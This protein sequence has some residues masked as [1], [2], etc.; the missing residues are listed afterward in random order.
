[1]REVRPYSQ[2]TGGSTFRGRRSLSS[3]AAAT[4]GGIVPSDGVCWM[5]RWKSFRKR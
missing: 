3:N 2:R 1:M 5:S 4:D